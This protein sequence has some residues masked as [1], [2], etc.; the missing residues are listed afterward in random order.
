L[1]IDNPPH[2]IRRYSILFL[3]MVLLALAASRIITLHG[4]EFNTDEVWSICKSLEHPEQII[5]WTP[6]DWPPLF[7]LILGGWK[8]FVGI[9]PIGYQMLSIFFYMLSAAVLCRVSAACVT[10]K[11]LMVIPTTARWAPLASAPKCAAT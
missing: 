6:Y 7:Y 8:A 2:P 3:S 9:Q 1:N 10:N 4:L 11:T 5:R